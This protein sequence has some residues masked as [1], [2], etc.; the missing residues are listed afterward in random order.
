MKTLINEFSS[1][2]QGLYFYNPK[3]DV[4]TVLKGACGD[5]FQYVSTQEELSYLLSTIQGNRII[6]YY[7]CNV[8]QLCYKYD[9]YLQK[10][11]LYW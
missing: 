6:I 4:V 3:S 9:N 10:M 5:E 2:K 7:N 8:K 1:R 11:T